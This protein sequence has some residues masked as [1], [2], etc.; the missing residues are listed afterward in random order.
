MPKKRKD[1]KREFTEAELAAAEARLRKAVGAPGIIPGIHNYCDRWCERCSKTANCSVFRTEELRTAER[2]GR[3]RVDDLKNDEM[4]S[5]IAE[6]MAVAMRMV[7]R[8]AKKRGIDLNALDP[9]V[10]AEVEERQRARD[11]ACEGS[12]LHRAATAYWRAAK[13]V[14]EALPEELQATEEA[15]N[16]QARLGAGDPHGA[17]AEIADALDV[18]QW[19]LFFIDVKLQRAVA[20]RVDERVEGLDGFPSDADGSAKVAL[21][22][23]DRSLGAWAR[24]RGHLDAHA[25]TILDLLVRLERLR[26]AAEREFPRARAFKRP[27]FD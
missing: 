3:R 13:A 15:L 26:R 4:W 1:R 11:A 25:D 14:L 27:G 17:A 7:L 10:E 23:I 18:V 16:T 12:G 22:A 8:D 20:G 2:G 6:S 24:L 21:I 9:A 5:D 19:Y